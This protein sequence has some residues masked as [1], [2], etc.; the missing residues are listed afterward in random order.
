MSIAMVSIF[1]MRSSTLNDRDSVQAG[2]VAGGVP[3]PSNATASVNTQ[4]ACTSM[5]LMRLPRTMTGSR[6][7]TRCCAR[8]AS[9]KPQLQKTMPALAPLRKPL[10]VSMTQFLP[11]LFFWFAAVRTFRR[12]PV[13]LA[14]CRQRDSRHAVADRSRINAKYTGQ[15]F[16]LCCGHRQDIVATHAIE[17]YCLCSNKLGPNMPTVPG[18]HFFSMT[19]KTLVAV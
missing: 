7:A 19:I 4:W 15:P 12:A 13:M 9:S 3:A 8:A 18:R 5:V 10:R 17:C 16:S 11:K 2:P 14:R 1:L 6:L